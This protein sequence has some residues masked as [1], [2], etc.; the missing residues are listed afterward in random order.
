[1]NYIYE[2][3]FARHGVIW[4]PGIDFYWK[5]ISSCE[6]NEKDCLLYEIIALGISWKS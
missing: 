5:L 2:G 1:M 3:Y 4:I 6:V